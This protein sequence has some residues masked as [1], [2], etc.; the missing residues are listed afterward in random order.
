MLQMR[1]VKEKK[2]THT[3]ISILTLLYTKT[4]YMLE[5][6]FRNVPLFVKILNKMVITKR[7]ITVTD[8]SCEI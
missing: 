5:N 2:H 3:F 7:I 6:V 1:S 8:L 4:L